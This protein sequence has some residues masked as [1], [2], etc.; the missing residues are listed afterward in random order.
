MQV[1]EIGAELQ[2]KNKV[3]LVRAPATP[4]FISLPS[5]QN[6][7]PA[8]GSKFCCGR[9]RTISTREHPAKALPSGILVA[10]TG[11]FAVVMRLAP[12]WYINSRIRLLHAGFIF[13]MSGVTSL[14]TT[15]DN[16]IMAL[17]LAAGNGVCDVITHP[18]TTTS[19]DIIE[20]TLLK[21]TA[22]SERSLLQQLLF[23]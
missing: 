13:H 9:A 7:D 1:L 3:F 11:I 15:Y 23:A 22:A 19:Y 12:F 4:G 18:P 2:C 21:D 16:V 6:T 20:V 17:P 14:T 8:L 5:P 10:P